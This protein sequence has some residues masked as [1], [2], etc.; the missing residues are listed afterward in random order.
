MSGIVYS[1][2][3][4][5]C[6]QLGRYFNI[7]DFD[8]VTFS[9]FA[10]LTQ[11]V[12][13]A[14]MQVKA[15]YKQKE[16]MLAYKRTSISALLANFPHVLKPLPITA[17]TTHAELASIVSNRLGIPLLDT[18]IDTARTVISTGEFVV[19]MATTST[20]Y[21]G[22]FKVY[23]AITVPDVID[24]TSKP[25]YRWPLAGDT[26]PSVG[27]VSLSSI[28]EYETIGAVQWAGLNTQRLE[29][30][31]V[32]LPCRGDFTLQFKLYVK[33]IGG[34]TL[35]LFTV[36]GGGNGTDVKIG[37]STNGKYYVYV[38][39]T[40]AYNGFDG[41]SG[42]VMP[43]GQE[44]LVTLRG[45]KGDRVEVYING[46]LSSVTDKTIAGDTAWTSF[47]KS[48]T[49]LGNTVR[50]RDIEYYDHA[51]DISPGQKYAK[52]WDVFSLWD[53]QPWY[54]DNSALDARGVSMRKYNP[55]LL[56]YG[57]DYTKYASFLKTIPAFPRPWNTGNDMMVAATLNS[58]RDAMIAVDGN[59]WV[60]TSTTNTAFNLYRAAVVY[61]GPTKNCGKV[62]TG[63]MLTTEYQMDDWMMKSFQPANLEYDNVL[64]FWLKSTWENNEGYG[65]VVML[66][67]NNEV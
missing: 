6:L 19:Y 56:T 20:Q 57:Y 52:T 43:I 45:V 8:R 55:G 9:E 24:R 13:D 12:G 62:V 40:I 46:A 34:D 37:K 3:N 47:G 44:S 22:S 31:G 67:Y 53:A 58:L 33:S 54:V 64:V 63:G 59:P 29:P 1:L 66:H 61:N 30:L 23:A 32:S 49:Y 16:Y 60:W 36:D 65:G 28:F 38:R 48:N 26:K 14:D 51:I 5:L 4:A 27:D 25:I 15:T 10:P 2:K 42:V 35:G 41:A 21:T 50:I 7:W 18:D 17:T 39:G 11:A